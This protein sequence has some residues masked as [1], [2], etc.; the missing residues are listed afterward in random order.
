MT[1]INQ[2]AS[3]RVPETRVTNDEVLLGYERII[4]G[5]ALTPS[6]APHVAQDLEGIEPS[7][8][9]LPAHEH[10]FAAIK[11]HAGRSDIQM[12]VTTA[13]IGDRAPRALNAIRQ[14]LPSFIIE[15]TQ[16]ADC[17]DAA[18]MHHYARLVR[19]AHGQRKGIILLE[20]IRT[21]FLA[22]DDAAVSLG[23]LGFADV[24]GDVPPVEHEDIRPMYGNIAALLDAGIPEP[25]SPDILHRQD[26]VGLF[27]RGKVNVLFGDPECGKTWIALAAIVEVLNRGGRAAFLDLDHN[28]MEEITSR[29]LL[30]GAHPAQLADT[31]RFRYCEPDD[32]VALEFFA[33]DVAAWRSDI[34]VVDSLGEVMPMLGLSSNSPDDFTTGNRKVMTRLANSGAGVVA[35]DH[36][37][38]DEG[39]RAH[40]QTGTVAK[41]RV[42]NGASLRVTAKD[43]FTPG[44]GGSA[45]ISIHKDRPGGLRR[46]SPPGKNA[47]AGRFV[48]VQRG[49]SV[50]WLVT[51]PITEAAATPQGVS[52]TDLSVVLN[53]PKEHRTRRKIQDHLGCGSDKAQRLLNKLRELGEGGID[54]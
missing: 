20:Q 4:L 36:L 2:R 12:R 23:L 25:P 49:E 34:A 26:Q 17:L 47:P 10:I 27:Y 53:L 15:C 30:L 13:L 22:G 50:E 44:H 46:H 52:T 42:A 5:Y 48:M 14:G 21:A 39:A 45:N 40:G 54:E 28:G 33:G 31:E 16:A 18:A 7:Q 38:K 6:N 9:L 8:F 11:D 51:R 24:L 29:L 35:I 43:Q 32:A 37:P 3:T 1:L 41:K 19:Q